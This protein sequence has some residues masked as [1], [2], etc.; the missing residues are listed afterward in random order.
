MSEDY[1]VE[2]GD[3]ISSIACARGF[4]WQTLWNDPSNAALKSKRQD[5]NVLMEGDV[6]HIPDL[7]AKQQPGSTEKRHKFKLK[8]VPAKL[9]IRVLRKGKPRKNEPY[10]L[11][12]DGQS[13]TG[14]TDGDGFVKGSL[15]PDAQEG[16]LTVGES[17]NQ[18]TFVLRFGHLDPMDSE[19]GVAGRLKN[20]GYSAAKDF[21]GAL[22][23]FQA[24]NG[25]PVT[26]E[27]DDATRNKLKELFGQ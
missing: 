15:P 17:G 23:K 10:R 7:T 11:V 25:L 14:T 16:K 20:L 27:A 26:G 2:Q 9:K 12:I 4:F 8:G 1:T 3:C 21:P 18:E 5:P 13:V 6:V 19:D 24:D 22:K